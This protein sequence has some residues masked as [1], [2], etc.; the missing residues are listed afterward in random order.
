M[1]VGNLRMFKM[2]PIG[3]IDTSKLR[4]G[5]HTEIFLSRGETVTSFELP[6][7]A[8]IRV[9]W[10]EPKRIKIVVPVGLDYSSFKDNFQDILHP[11]LISHL[12]TAWPEDQASSI[13]KPLPLKAWDDVEIELIPEKE[14]KVQA[15]VALDRP[16]ITI[17][18]G[19][20]VDEFSEN[21]KKH[22]KPELFEHVIRLW[23]DPDYCRTV[24]PVG[25]NLLIRGCA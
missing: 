19:Q 20:R 1:S 16:R 23:S 21:C 18:M 12:H 22:L 13:G 15:E 3:D 8:P 10:P 14:P 17:Q 5:M 7:S 24:L 4:G 25:R 11:E 2:F 6:S 9:S